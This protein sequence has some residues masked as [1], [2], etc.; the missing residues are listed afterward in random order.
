MSERLLARLK[1]LGVAYE[2]PLLKRL[3]SIGSEFYPD[4][5]VHDLEDE[6]AFLF[7]VVSDDVLLKAL[8]P[9]REM[10]KVAMR[11]TGWSLQIQRA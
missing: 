9:L 2:L 8:A 7:N 10:I 6:L 1:H 4:I 5:Q 3:P 11:S